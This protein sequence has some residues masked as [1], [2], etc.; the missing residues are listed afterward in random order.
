MNNYHQKCYLVIG[1][2]DIG[3][4]LTRQLAQTGCQVVG[5]SRTAKCHANLPITHWQM[6]AL[7]LDAKRLHNITHIAI[8]V[9]PDTQK[10]KV[11]AYQDSYLAICQH[12]AS[13]AD[14][15]PQ[16]RQILFV[17]STAVYSENAGEVVNEQM[18]AQPSTPTAK[19]L[20]DAEQVI[21][22][23]FGDKA[24]I[25]RPSGIYGVSRRRMLR[26]AKTAHGDGVPS[27]HYTN[28]IMD[29]DLVMVLWHILMQS[30][31]K[32]IYIAT[33]FCP[34]SSREVLDFLCQK[35]QYQ[36]LKVIDAPATGKRL[37]S[38]LPKEWLQFGDYRQGYTHIVGNLT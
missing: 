28:R 5:L 10:D 14:E 22:K 11:R 4:S 16:I 35:L 13:L 30:E 3:L 17:S 31:P 9:S 18:I 32:P 25:V 36:P 26:L 27:Q 33:D 29:T 7:E 19:V 23:A 15:L 2:G 20:Y 37:V 38:N 21:V 34:A 6:N 24:V 12:M 8:I 1:Q